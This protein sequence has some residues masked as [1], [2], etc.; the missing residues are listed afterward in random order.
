M[1]RATA[2]VALLD[3]ARS[4]QSAYVDLDRLAAVGSGFSL[5]VKR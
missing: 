1:A 4:T 5:G 2:R 3:D